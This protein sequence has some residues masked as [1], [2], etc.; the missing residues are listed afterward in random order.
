MPCPA[1]SLGPT[2]QVPL[3]PAPGAT[4]TCPVCQTKWVADTFW[5]MK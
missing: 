4:W 2:C 5:R 1:D 3:M